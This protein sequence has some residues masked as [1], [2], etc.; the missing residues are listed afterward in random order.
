MVRKEAQR[1]DGG[2]VVLKEHDYGYLV[3]VHKEALPPHYSKFHSKLAD[4]EADFERL[5]SK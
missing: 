3:T 5:A 4:A 2:T 1:A